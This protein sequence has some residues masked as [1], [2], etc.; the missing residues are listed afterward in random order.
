MEQT[1]DAAAVPADQLSMVEGSEAVEQ[2]DDL[3]L[4]SIGL[5]VFFLSLIVVVGA[6]L[7]LPAIF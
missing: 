7:I 4:A 6:L 1:S 5:A 2:T 3:D